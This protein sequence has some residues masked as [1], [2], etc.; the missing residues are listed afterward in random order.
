[1]YTYAAACTMVTENKIKNEICDG[2]IIM[3]TIKIKKNIM[4]TI[5]TN[6]ITENK[7]KNEICDGVNIMW[8]IKIKNVYTYICIYMYVCIYIC[9]YVS[10]KSK[11]KSV[12]E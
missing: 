4:W 12:M 2:V 10:T 3:W 1:M 7:I 8:T 11:T 5:N 6:L 9:M